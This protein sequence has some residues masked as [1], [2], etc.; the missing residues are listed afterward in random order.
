MQILDK[1]FTL[2]PFQIEAEFT[3]TFIVSTYFDKLLHHQVE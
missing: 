2:A 3:E 1:L